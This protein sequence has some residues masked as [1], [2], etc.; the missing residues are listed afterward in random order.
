MCTKREMKPERGRA[1]LDDEDEKIEDVD[2]LAPC[3]WEEPPP[4]LKN[5][6]ALLREWCDL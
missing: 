2:R 5:E 1:L 4:R 3:P 6:G